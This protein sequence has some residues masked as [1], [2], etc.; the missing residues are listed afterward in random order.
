MY[1][2]LKGEKINIWNN[3]N[4]TGIVL[5]VQGVGYEIQLLPR[6]IKD[7]ESNKYIELWVHQ[8]QRD[9]SS[10][11]YGFKHLKERD[12]FRKLISIS[13]IGPQ[14]GISLLEEMNVNLLIKAIHTK[15]IKT[16]TKAQGV[17][18]KMAERIILDL[19][20]KLSEFYCDFNKEK[21]INN[22]K[23]TE[24]KNNSECFF[25]LKSTLKSLGYESIEINQ[26]LNEEIKEITN[27]N[28]EEI[29]SSIDTYSELLLK[30]TLLR[31]AQN[32]S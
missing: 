31:L 27:Q 9:D 21:N 30:G 23:N 24:L 19:N 4:R 10:Y 18:N 11:L 8:I 5:A 16:L 25:E 14:I 26:A 1:S 12:I 6:Q 28:N 32:I 15:D 20:S 7:L 17:G 3:G 2:W 22:E 13:G 29:T